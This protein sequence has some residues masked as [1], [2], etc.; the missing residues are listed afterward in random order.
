MVGVI[1]TWGTVLK[2]GSIRKVE[3][4]WYRLRLA[5][6]DVCRLLS[7]LALALCEDPCWL[8][9]GSFPSQGLVKEEKLTL[10]QTFI[11]IFFLTTAATRLATLTLL[12]WWDVPRVIK[13]KYFLRLLFIR[14]FWREKR[15][16]TWCV[17]ICMC[18]GQKIVSACLEP[19]LQLVDASHL[20][21]MPGAELGPLQERW[22]QSLGHHPSTCPGNFVTASVTKAYIQNRMVLPSLQQFQLNRH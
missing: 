6:G 13:P 8:W 5:F 4:H 22:S 17:L 9:V 7:W 3:E 15:K 19:E 20:T 12:P 21:W 18:R 11:A 10:A 1:I 2:G 16:K 14:V